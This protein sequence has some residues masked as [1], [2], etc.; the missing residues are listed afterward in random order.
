MHD[1]IDWFE[2]MLKSKWSVFHLCSRREQ[3]EYKHLKQWQCIHVMRLWRNVSMVSVDKIC[4][5]TEIL[6][7]TVGCPH[8]GICHNY[9]GVY[10]SHTIIMITL[11][12]FYLLGAFVTLCMSTIYSRFGNLTELLWYSKIQFR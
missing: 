6:S 5:I 1:L 3:L 11:T 9:I 7:Y 2:F 12:P 4:L 10:Y 8:R